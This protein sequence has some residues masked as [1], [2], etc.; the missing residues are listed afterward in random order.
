MAETKNIKMAEF[1][2]K[3]HYKLNSHIFK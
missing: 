1:N 2:L 3:E